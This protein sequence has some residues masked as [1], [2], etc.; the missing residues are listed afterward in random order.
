[1]YDLSSYGTDSTLHFS[2]LL[3]KEEILP[4]TGELHDA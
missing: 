1:M 3:Q 4:V 2:N